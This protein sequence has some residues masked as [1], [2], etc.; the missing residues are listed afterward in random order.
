MD[1]NV[2]VLYV[3]LFPLRLAAFCN[4][5]LMDKLFQASTETIILVYGIVIFICQYIHIH[6]F[7]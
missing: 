6:S 7:M 1:S 2:N 5:W 3:F 4:P